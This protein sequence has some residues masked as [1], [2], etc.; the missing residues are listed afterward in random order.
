[1][2]NASIYKAFEKMWLYTTTSIKKLS[3]KVAF[4]T[5]DN[6]VV[7]DPEILK[8][9]ISADNI[10]TG[11]VSV[12][13]G[14]TG[15]NSFEIGKVLVGN[16]NEIVQREIDTTLDGSLESENLITSGAVYAALKDEITAEDISAIVV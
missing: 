14:G 9:E 11:T 3:S 7:L 5:I 6:E 2:I 16:G 1:M 13:R 4:V 12:E 10:V 8:E 15:K